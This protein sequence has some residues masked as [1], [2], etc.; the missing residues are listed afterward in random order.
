MT[1][2]DE[3][4][5]VF[6][7]IAAKAPPREPIM[8]RTLKML[9]E[10][11]LGRQD[12]SSMLTRGTN[13]VVR[14]M[15]RE[16]LKTISGEE[17]TAAAQAAITAKEPGRAL[18]TFDKPMFADELG[19]PGGVQELNAQDLAKLSLAFDEQ[20]KVNAA[21]GQGNL[22]RVVREQK[23][24]GLTP[25]ERLDEALIGDDARNK[26]GRFVKGTLMGGNAMDDLKG[27][28][29]EM[30]RRVMG[31]ERTV[32]NGTHEAI[33]LIS[34]AALN[35]DDPKYWD[36][37]YKYLSG[38]N[39]AF[40]QGGRRVVSSGTNTT[41]E[42]LTNFR[43][44]LQEGMFADKLDVLKRWAEA[45]QDVSTP[46]KVRQAFTNLSKADQ[47]AISEVLDTLWKSEVGSLYVRDLLVALRP[48]IA[49]T[50]S[51]LTPDVLG[52]LTEI[53]MYHGGLVARN[54]KMI[55][56]LTDEQ[57]TR[58]FLGDLSKTFGKEAE[59]RAAILTAT[60]GLAS[61]ARK[62]MASAGLALDGELANL[63]TKWINGEFVPP[64]K[65]T[66]LRQFADKV[67]FD[68]S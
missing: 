59:G 14:R 68:S 30:R 38:E 57:M 10:Q 13:E 8:K 29:P 49:R 60:H 63:W 44:S 36:K 11:L 43:R 18:I 21:M 25:A 12:R 26:V 46:Q 24:E 58:S 42:V 55:D 67:G 20:R 62:D 1:L 48:E 45:V 3:V 32:A 33:R 7:D 39:V 35:K 51:T 64:D 22:A 28:S 40:E 66:K 23:M 34:E 56:G 2:A 27:L 50:S 5:D 4:E 52:P 19:V 53:L 31:A 65:M 41:N 15:R 17:L 47:A 16:G 6:A 61:Q 54:G 9:D 37:I